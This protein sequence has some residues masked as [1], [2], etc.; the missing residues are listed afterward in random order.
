MTTPLPLQTQFVPSVIKLPL[1]AA[2]PLQ[3]L[4]ASWCFGLG[5]ASLL[6]TLPTLPLVYFLPSTWYHHLTNIHY[7]YVPCSSSIP[8]PLQPHPGPQLDSGMK[9]T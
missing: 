2:P 9:A 3:S 7:T 8:L 6:A 5:R 1:P 4:P